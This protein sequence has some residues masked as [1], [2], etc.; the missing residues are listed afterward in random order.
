MNKTFP[1]F[2][3]GK[4]TKDAMNNYTSNN[5]Y[6]IECVHRTLGVEESIKVT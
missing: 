4:K 1:A 3:V 5:Y 2:K 6:S